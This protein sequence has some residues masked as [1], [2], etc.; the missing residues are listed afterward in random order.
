MIVKDLYMDCFRYEESSLAHCIYHLL[1]EQKISIDE[2]ISKIDLEQADHQKVRELVQ[3]NVLGIHKVGIYS[4]KMNQK[5]FV[6]IFA[7]RHKE[8]IQFYTETFH[9]SPLNCHEYS[10]DYQH[11]RGNDV[12]SFRD[13]RKEF[14]SLPAIAGYFKR[15]DESER[16][17]TNP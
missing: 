2:D 16:D 1:A 15:G 13:M 9:Q 17:G 6:F 8:A 12:I 4:L 10:L 3:N 7:G 14:M 11:A 5:D